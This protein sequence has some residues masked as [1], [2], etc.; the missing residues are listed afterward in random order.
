MGTVR[1]FLRRWQSLLPLVL[2][3]LLA[4]SAA[5]RPAATTPSSTSAGP[6][7]VSATPKPAHLNY[8]LVGAQSWTSAPDIVAQAK[9]FYAA[10][11]LTV[12]FVVTGQ[13]AS[14][15]QQVLAKAAEIGACSIGDMIQAVESS[16]APLIQFYGEYAAPL[17]YSIMTKPTVKT[18]ADLKGKTIMVGGPKDN[19]VYFFRVMARANGLKDNDYD[20]EYAGAS[21]ARFAALKAG[22]VDGSIL[23]DPYDAQAEQSG[24]FKLDTLVPKYVNAGNYGYVIAAARKDWA[25]DNPDVLSRFIRAELRA[26]NW[27]YDPANKAELFS[28]VGPKANIAQADLERLYQR[29][30]VAS[31]FWST[32][33]KITDSGVQGVLDSLVDVG[34]L[35]KPTP[36]PS[37]YYDLTYD[38]AALKS[39]AR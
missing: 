1:S 21:S 7:A 39:M 6:A 31:K 18:W 32:D 29:D 8:A 10:E 3:A 16:G 5:C 24:D 34:S 4:A 12:D 17:N 30:V 38:N 19:T 25:K 33:G 9:G 15:C 2:V 27:V 20:F 22:A 36:P 26:V 37:K 11:N 23:T 13:S 28:L 35:N 14:A